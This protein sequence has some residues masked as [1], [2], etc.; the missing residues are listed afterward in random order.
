MSQI[1]PSKPINRRQLIKKISHISL[2][3]SA[4]FAA[5]SVDYQKP[6]LKKLWP[7]KDAAAVLTS[8]GITP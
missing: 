6:T 3:V 4:T 1:N 5:L 7:L 2:G 8:D